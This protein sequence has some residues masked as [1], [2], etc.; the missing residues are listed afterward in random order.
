MTS[1]SAL[2][3]CAYVA[4][5]LLL[6]VPMGRWLAAVAQGRMARLQGFDAALLRPIGTASNSTAAT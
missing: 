5:V 1:Q 4:A 3:L 2:L 6:A